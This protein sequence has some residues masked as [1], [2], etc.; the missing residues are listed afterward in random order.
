MELLKH[1]ALYSQESKYFEK[2]WFLNYE[3]FIT[4]KQSRCSKVVDSVG[5][6]DLSDVDDVDPGVT[7]DHMFYY[8]DCWS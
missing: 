4:E 6:A 7:F 5:D 1:K 3:Y 8:V 2:S